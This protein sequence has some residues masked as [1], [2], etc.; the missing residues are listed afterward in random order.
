[1]AAKGS[2][3]A[4]GQISVIS[5]QNAYSEDEEQSPEFSYQSRATC[6][7]QMAGVRLFFQDFKCLTV[8]GFGDLLDVTSC[9]QLEVKY[10]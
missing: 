3:N 1:M 9:Q 8:F 2:C 6:F 5:P 4:S 7:C 10:I